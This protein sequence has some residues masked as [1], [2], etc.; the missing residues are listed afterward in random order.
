MPSWS[1]FFCIIYIAEI[2][3]Y[4]RIWRNSGN[5]YFRTLQISATITIRWLPDCIF[6]FFLV[7]CKN[8]VAISRKPDIITGHF[9]PIKLIV[10]PVCVA[11]DHRI[12][13]CFFDLIAKCSGNTCNLGC[14]KASHF[15]ILNIKHYRIRNFISVHFFN[16]KL[17]FLHRLLCGSCKAIYISSHWKPYFFCLFHIIIVGLIQMI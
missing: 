10:I 2:N 12:I 11:V 16:R 6:V 13:S 7:W 4:C 8:L 9:T 3:V 5:Q 1:N 14:R 15:F 17:C